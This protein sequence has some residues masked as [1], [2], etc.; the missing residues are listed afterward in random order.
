MRYLRARSWNVH[1]AT[2]MLLESLK[3]RASYKPEELTFDNTRQ[4]AERG[5]LFILSKPDLEG[6]PV[7]MMR[8]RNEEKYTGDSEERIKWLVYT[9]EQASRLAD[10][11]CKC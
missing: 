5:K 2:K 6:R 11:S 1:K 9:L 4:E 8:P 10:E 3:W 7:V